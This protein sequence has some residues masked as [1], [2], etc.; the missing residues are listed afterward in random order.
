MGPFASVDDYA[1]RYGAPADPEKVGTSV[2][3]A[4]PFLPS[5]PAASLPPRAR[6]A[7]GAPASIAWQPGFCIRENDAVQAANLV[8]I[9]C[10]VVHRS[11]SAGDWAGLS[12]ASQA[13]GSYNASVTIANPTEDFYLTKAE[14]RSLGL[15]GGRIGQTCPYSLGGRGE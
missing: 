15:S 14:K 8:R 3:P 4:S 9:A 11:L 7:A 5:P 1:D 10:A 2:G 12:S 13:A 6:G